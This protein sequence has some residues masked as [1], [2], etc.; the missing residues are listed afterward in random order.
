[1]G[2]SLLLSNKLLNNNNDKDKDEIYQTFSKKPSI[3]KA[4][5]IIKDDLDKIIPK[6]YSDKIEELK[7]SKI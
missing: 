7:L 2:L 6:K 4:F 3:E 1:M 5:E